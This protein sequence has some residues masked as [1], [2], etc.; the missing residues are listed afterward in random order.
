MGSKGGDLPSHSPST[1]LPSQASTLKFAQGT[2]QNRGAAD[3]APSSQFSKPAVITAIQPRKFV[4]I[5]NSD[6]EGQLFDLIAAPLPPAKEPAQKVNADGSVDV[7]GKTEDG[8]NLFRHF[9]PK[10]ELTKEG[11]NHPISG[12]NIFRSFYESGELKAMS[13][14][15]ADKSL[16]SIDFTQSGLHE[17]RFDRQPD[18]TTLATNYDDAGEVK[19]IWRTE[20][21]QKPSKIFP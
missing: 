1:E 19:E 13:W 8:K 21:G 3:I 14:T 16:T 2:P 20:K 6:I 10:G 9:N 11:W 18:G 4:P 17:S 7:Y 15:R 5:L 12:E